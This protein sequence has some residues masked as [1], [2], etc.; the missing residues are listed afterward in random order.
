M[1]DLIFV[2]RG[3][4]GSILSH[5][6]QHRYNVTVLE[7]EPE[8]A[9]VL[10]DPPSSHPVLAL[11]AAAEFPAILFEALKQQVCSVPIVW[12]CQDINNRDLPDTSV[13]KYSCDG[14]NEWTVFRDVLRNYLRPYRR[15]SANQ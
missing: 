4:V 15:K 6:I 14:T 8:P 13:L 12:L 2:Y 7:Y 3:T 11:V 1:P 5:Y 9:D 10:H